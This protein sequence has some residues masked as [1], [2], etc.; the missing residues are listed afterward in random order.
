[1]KGTIDDSTIFFDED[2]LPAVTLSINSL[3]DPSKSRGSYST[4][5]NV[6]STPE[7]RRVLGTE[8]M[9]QAENKRRPRLRIGDGGV[10]VFDARIVVVRKDRDTHECVALG[11][12]AEWFDYAKATKLSEFDFGSTAPVT[13]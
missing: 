6:V 10:D 12:N 2:T 7:A 8:F 13:K 9:A 4:T 5:I 3:I 1:M 11:G